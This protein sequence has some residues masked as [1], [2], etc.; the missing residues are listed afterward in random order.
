MLLT[1]TEIV[2][3]Y[4]AWFIGICVLVG[5]LYAFGLYYKSRMFG[6]KSVQINRILAPLRFLS[7]TIICLLLLSPIIKATYTESKPPIVVLAQDNSESILASMD[8]AARAAYRQKMESLQAQLKDKYNLQTYSFGDNIQDGIDFSFNHKSTNIAQVLDQVY[9]A[10]SGQ[11]LATVILATD[12]IYNQGNNPI[13]SGTR[14]NTPIFS[15]ALG[16]T[17]PRRDLVVKKVYNNQIAYLGDKFS[18][19]V[20]IAAVNCSGNSTKLTVRKKG[21]TLLEKVVS[22]ANNDFFI[23]EEVILDADASG[24]QCYEVSLSGIQGEVTTANNS[25]DVCIDILDTRQKILLLAESP[26]PDIACL[27]RMIDLGKNYEVDIA[28]AGQLKKSVA[29]YD[30]VVLHQLPSMRSPISDVLNSLSSKNIPHLFVVGTQSNINAFNQAQ[31]ILSISGKTTQTNDTE[32]TLAAGFNLFTLSTKVADNVYRFPPLTTPFG[33]FTA[34]GGATVILKQKIGA[35]NTD[36]PLLVIGEERG[37]KK[38]VLAGEGMWKWRLNDYMQRSNHEVFDELMGKVVQYL[39]NKE[40]KRRFRAMASNTIY[41]ENEAIVIDAELYNTNYERINEPEARLEITNE[42]GQKFPFTFNKTANA[43]TLNA[44]IFPTGSYKF[45]AKTTF[46]GETLLAKGEF[47]VKSIQLEIFETTA[48]HRLLQ[49]ISQKSGGQV[50]Y[51][52]DLEKI[53][54]LIDAQG[55]AKPQLFDTVRTRSLIH[56]KWIFFLILGLLSLEWFLRRYNGGY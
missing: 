6:E 40:D 10:Y 15:I 53:A 4:P 20:D 49:V 52:N 24:V 45:E 27:R 33:D 28:Y 19:Q 29:E 14:L 50:V 8:E 51:P 39:S 16:D 36:Y 1:A 44:G 54:E 56:F 32:G 7:V 18:M 31:G 34:R 21:K 2:L 43:Y 47:T 30:F 11:N 3:Q 23:T 26:H 41:N 22:I 35:I 13:Y 17:I 55:V 5:F 12:G 25:K 42:K 38:G 46:N 48:D 37:T 9:D